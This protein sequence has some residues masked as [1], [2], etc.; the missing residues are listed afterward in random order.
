MSTVS[1]RRPLAVIAGLGN[2]SGTGASSA[3]LFAKHGYTIALVARHRDDSLANLVKEIKDAGGD[4]AY[5]AVPE[6]SRDAISSAFAEIR[7]Q[8]PSS[9][10]AIRVAIFNAA[11]GVWK[12]FL[13]VTPEDIQEAVD[14]NIV[15]AFAFSREAIVEFKSNDLNEV[16]KRGI[17]IFTGATASI[18]GNVITSAFAA[19]KAGQRSL[20]QSLAKEFG[21][22]NIQVSHAII[23]GGILTDRSR[24]RQNN[25]PEWINNAD[26]RLDP[27]SIAASYLYLANQDRSAWTWELDLRPAHEK[28]ESGISKRLSA[29]LL[30]SQARSNGMPF[31]RAN[32]SSP[33]SKRIKLEEPQDTVSFQQSSQPNESTEDNC[34][35]CLQSISDRTVVPLCSHEFCF[36]C[37]LIW[38]DQSRRCPLCSQQIGEYL[39]HRIRS[40]YDYEKYFLPPLRSSPAPPQHSTQNSALSNRNVRRGRPRVQRVWGRRERQQLEEADRLDRAI[41]KRRWIYHHDLYAKHVASNT[42]TRYRPYPTPAQFSA[43]PEY[44]SRAT[45]FLRR[46]LRV[47]PNLDVEFLTTFVISLMKAI[48]IRSESAVKLLAEFLD[49]DSEPRR[50]GSPSASRRLSQARSSRSTSPSTSSRSRSPSWSPSGRSHPSSRYRQQEFTAG[51]G[52][53]RG[54]FIYADRAISPHRGSHH[55]AKD[56]TPTSSVSS[57]SQRFRGASHDGGVRTHSVSDVEGKGKGKAPA[58]DDA[59]ISHGTQIHPMDHEGDREQ[60]R[61][62]ANEHRL[63]HT[64]ATGSNAGEKASRVGSHIVTDADRKAI[65]VGAKREDSTAESSME[66]KTATSMT[67]AVPLH[68][69][70]A[71]P[72][73]R[74][75][76]APRNLNL[77]K[78]VQAYL[79]PQVKATSRDQRPM[80]STAQ[81]PLLARLSDSQSDPSS[82]ELPDTAADDDEHRTYLDQHGVPPWSADS[83]SHDANIT[84]SSPNQ[85]QTNR[86]GMSAVQIMARTRARLAKSDARAGSQT[87][88]TQNGTI[89]PP[90]TEAKPPSTSHR[91]LGR[92]QVEGR[93]DDNANPLIAC[94]RIAHFRSGARTLGESSRISSLTMNHGKSSSDSDRPVEENGEKLGT[95]RAKLLS[96]LADEKCLV[97]QEHN[98]L[99][100][101]PSG[102]ASLMERSSTAGA[103]IM[104]DDVS[105]REAALRNRARLK[106]RLAN[107]KKGI[108]RDDV[109]PVG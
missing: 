24:E 74:V 79:A 46:E 36:E 26:V 83:V 41:A 86:S 67:S 91:A 21:K 10:Y 99:V 48:D 104:P 4:A 70:E 17:L 3:R 19:G 85:S 75:R 8:F 64:G 90:S 1:N 92:V 11:H 103:E 105:A 109:S 102:S 57:G 43:S 34:S 51:A 13:D 106:V 54:A 77:L 22:D 65:S 5:F 61:G 63:Q 20:S 42:H 62:A 2:G 107:A 9:T 69:T 33:V 7:K 95:L 40:K 47:W 108:Q 27:D 35:I 45:A 98:A 60:S 30:P 89:L 76:R 101:S 18:R 59:L 14:V 28:W 32:S 38:T 80:T 96:K 37:L 82:V 100:A 71:R 94:E 88:S 68:G 25:N 52:T 56:V 97:Q 66:P 78:S 6:Y 50:A 39:I 81:K 58:R 49:M 16:G 44:I 23:D 12:P 29:R 72:N 15:A 93:S 55:V 87:C 73:E 53:S 84:S 31:N